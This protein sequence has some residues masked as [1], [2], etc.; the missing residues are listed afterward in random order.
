[1]PLTVAQEVYSGPPGH[2]RHARQPFDMADATVAVPTD[3]ETEPEAIADAQRRDV[4]RAWQ[5]ERGHNLPRTIEAAVALISEEVLL[6]AWTVR[7]RL[8]ELGYEVNEPVRAKNAERK[9]L[10]VL[11]EEELR[12]GGPGTTAEL[13]GRLGYQKCR[14]SYIGLCLSNL[15]HNGR[16]RVVGRSASA[17]K[18]RGGKPIFGIVT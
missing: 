10:S 5:K 9:K 16:V 17:D 3:P 7:Q 18:R 15:L 6:D 11:L 1:M 2:R 12:R 4:S 14:G 13:R 8:R